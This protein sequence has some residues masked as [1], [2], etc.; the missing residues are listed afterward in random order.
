MVLAEALTAAWK[1][2]G[3]TEVRDHARRVVAHLE[4]LTRD[5]QLVSFE[6]RRLPLAL[7]AAYEHLDPAEKAARA[8]AHL[9]AHANTLLAALRNSKAS[10]PY[11]KAT[12]QVAGALM[13][14][15]V[16]L[17][18]PDAARVFDALLTVLNDPNRERYP[19]AS[20]EYAIKKIIVRLDEGDV[21]RILGHLRAV[22]LQGVI[23]E[24]RS[25]AKHRSFRD[26]WDYLDQTPSNENA[27]AA[28]SAKPND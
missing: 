23:L 17:D 4:D 21:Q 6:P 12:G 10:D 28:P 3:T 20:H 1:G 19:L 27:T 25:E 13:A 7:A 18:R 26:M 9:A 2:A 5:P 11:D 14:L 8:N 15:C 16:H 22:G 24:A